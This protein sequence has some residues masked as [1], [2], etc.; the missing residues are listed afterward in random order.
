[1]SFTRSLAFVLSS[2]VLCG[3]SL[4]AK[5]DWSRFRGPNGSGY[6]ETEGLPAV[7]DP[8]TTLWQVTIGPGWSAPSLWGDKVFLTAEVGAA[9]RAVICLSAADGAELWRHEVPFAEHRQHKFNS[10][11]TATP[12]VDQQRVYVTWTS[13]STVQALALTHGGELLWH[14]DHVANY[15]HEHGSGVSPVVA[16]GVLIVRS[17][18]STEKNDQVYATPEQMDWTSGIYGLD[19]TTGKQVW[20]LDL[21]N[22]INPYSTPLLRKTGKGG[23]EFI[24]A[25]TTSGFLGVDVKTG[26]VNWQHNPEFK[27]RSVASVVIGGNVIFAPLGSGDGGKESALLDLSSDKPKEIGS[28]IKNIPYVP[29]PL[30][31]KDRL[32][33]LRDG[34]IFTCS[35]WPSGEELY[36]E[37]VTGGEGRSTKYF[38][39]PVAGDG[40]IFCASQTGE[41]IAIKEGDQFEVLGVSKLDAPINSTPAI[42]DGRIYVRT[43]KSLWCASGKQLT[44]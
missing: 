2:S 15:I 18:F 9:K 21:P 17:E 39:S 6:A 16:D 28:I 13:G 31:I 20:K 33:M 26:K 5:T 35:K 3:G 8:S 14:N 32:Y 38:S 37:R 22:T 12:Y 34:G 29:T 10:F 41:L 43:E 25:N 23:T 36:T 7:I 42:G 27:Q 11:A 44:P 40:K 4:S 24:V 30:V 1:M 19:V